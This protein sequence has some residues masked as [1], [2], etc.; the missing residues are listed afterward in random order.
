MLKDFLQSHESKNDTQ[1]SIADARG[2]TTS[3]FWIVIVMLI[4]SVVGEAEGLFGD[5][6]IFA[7]AAVTAALI[8]KIGRFV[9]KYNRSKHID[10]VDTLSREIAETVDDLE[11]TIEDLRAENLRLIQERKEERTTHEA[12]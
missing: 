8:Y 10:D 12:T 4:A 9:L 5:S 6:H 2:V 1:R 7:I 11:A 3:E